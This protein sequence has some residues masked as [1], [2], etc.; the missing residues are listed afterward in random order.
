MARELHDTLAQ[1]LAG[2]I[3][4]LEAVDEL[5]G[6]G[7]G[8]M[9]RKITGRAMQRARATLQEART[10]IQ[11][12][13]SPLE[14]GDVMEAI[15]RLVDNLTAD[16]GILCAFEAGPGDL[17]IDG[18]VAETVF[19]V[20]Q[21]GLVNI[22]RHSQAGWAWVKLS[23]T[24]GAISLEVGDDGVGFDP[25][26][27]KEGHFGLTGLRERVGLA[28]G[29]LQVESAPGAGTRL[30]VTLPLREEAPV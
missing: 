24:A 21:E 9:A 26:A 11:A 25:A 7:D 8:E 12:L 18:P 16:T 1:G 5:L 13:R 14:Q 17:H 30:I 27:L 20:V 2:L 10:A 3:M 22:A 19:R 29:T 15:R 28:D 23:A 4:Q 6:R